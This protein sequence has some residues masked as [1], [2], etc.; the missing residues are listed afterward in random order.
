M[1]TIA[2]HID[3]EIYSKAEQKAVALSTS[4]PD[5]MVDYLRHWAADDN[6]IEDARQRMIELFAHPQHEFGVGIPDTREERNARR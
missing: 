6:R 1:K 4:V 3:D 2:I 5:V